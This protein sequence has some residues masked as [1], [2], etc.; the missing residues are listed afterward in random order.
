M[1]KGRLM[2]QPIVICSI[3]FDQETKTWDRDFVDKQSNHFIKTFYDQQIPEFVN[4]E[5]RET[6]IIQ[7]KN[8]Y[9]RTL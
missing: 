6:N 7:G 4:A 9:L 8:L 1:S 3:L 2:R 5:Q